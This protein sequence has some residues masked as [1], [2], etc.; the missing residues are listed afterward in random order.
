VSGMDRSFSG[1]MPEFYDRFLVPLMFEP[2]ARRLAACLKG[3][4]SGH[5]LEIATGTGVVTRAL[6]QTLPATVGITATDLNPAML[7]WAR[8]YPGMARVVWQEADALAL[9]FPDRHFDKV[10]CQFGV[11][12]FPDKQAAFR[13]ILRVLRPGGEF[14]FNVWAR[15]DGTVQQLS[16]TVVGR[17]L[18]TEPDAMLAPDY[19]NANQIMSDLAA[20]GFDKFVVEELSERFCA[21]SARQAAVA[22]CHGGLIRSHIEASAPD[23]LEAITDAVADAIA[24]EFGTGPIDAPLHAKL[25]ACVRGETD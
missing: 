5:V 7:S 11:M 20:A 13:E 3:M 16:S 23:R 17:L 1:A 9:P 25:I 24:S 2:F 12:F 18:G 10:V 15:R 14:L 8:T 4:E 6:V 19:S 21:S 22:T